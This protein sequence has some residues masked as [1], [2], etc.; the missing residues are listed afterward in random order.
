VAAIVATFN[1]D[2]AGRAITPPDGADLVWSPTNAQ[3]SVLSVINGATLSLAVEDE[4]MDDPTITSALAA[5]ARRGV[6]VTVIMTANPE[7]DAA[8]AELARAGVHVRLYARAQQV[9]DRVA[10]RPLRL[11]P[12]APCVRRSPAQRADTGNARWRL[13]G[14]RREGIDAYPGL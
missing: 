1:A 8:F 13:R 14:C 2:F 4:E 3:A 6:D 7:W 12:A 11:R 10:R 9:A 5:A